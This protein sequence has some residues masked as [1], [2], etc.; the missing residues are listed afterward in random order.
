MK[1]GVLVVH[2]DASVDLVQ[3]LEHDGEEVPPGK[4]AKPLEPMGSHTATPRGSPII[5]PGRVTDGILLMNSSAIDS[6]VYSI[7]Y[8]HKERY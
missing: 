3:G 1:V 6:Y 2:A 4:D 8:I 5:L 7:K